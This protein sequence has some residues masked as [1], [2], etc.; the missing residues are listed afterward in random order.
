VNGFQ[1][2]YLGDDHV[3]GFEP[4]FAVF[5]TSRQAVVRGGTS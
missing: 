2:G 1:F 5:D 3:A 4:V